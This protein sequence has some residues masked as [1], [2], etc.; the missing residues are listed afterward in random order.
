MEENTITSNVIWRFA[1]RWTTQLIS[2]LISVIISRILSPDDFGLVALTNIFMTIVGVFTDSGLSDS[3]IQKKD[4]DELD[5]STA[6][7]TNIALCFFIY[8]LAFVCA[9]L[10]SSFYGMPELTGLIR[11]LSIRIIISG[12]K[13]I[14][15]AYVAK[16]MLFKKY[17]FASIIGTIISGVVGIIMAYKGFGAWSLVASTLVD[18][19]I[20]TILCWLAVKWVPVIQFSFQRLKGLMNFGIKILFIRVINNIYNKLSQLVTGKFYTKADLAYFDK[21]DNL[22]SKLTDNIDNTI[23]SVLFPAVSNIQ[24][25]L[26]RVKEVSKKTLQINTYIIYPLLVGLFVVSN[27]AVKLIFTEKWIKC[28]PFIQVFCV[29]KLTLPL[30][31]INKNITKSLGG[32]SILLKQELAIK[33]ISIIVILLTA[34]IGPMKIAYGLLFNNVISVIIS[35]STSRSN[36]GY[37][38][39]NQLLDIAPNLIISLIMG[40]IVYMTNFTNVPL[41][42]NLMIKILIGGFVYISLS[43]ISK[44]SSYR[45]IVD[46]IIK[47]FKRD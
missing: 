28:V 35:S 30:I 46:L 8:G 40:A 38:I 23:E 6:F 2:L 17:F 1:D 3:L 20:D 33:I 21:G 25:D 4:A 9:P 7:F 10:V 5:F 27:D 42:F 24:N 43:Y 47:K 19:G 12:F 11:V 29:I 26:S 34:T 15:H 32:S 22:S 13:N 37:S 14:H 41:I 36:A 16:N 45:F 39:L 31:T 44:N 18:V